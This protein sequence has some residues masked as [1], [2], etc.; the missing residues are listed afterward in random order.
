MILLYH[1]TPLKM[2][3]EIVVM[4]FGFIGGAGLYC[5][6]FFKYTKYSYS[7]FYDFCYWF[8]GVVFCISSTLL[9][10]F[11]LSLFTTIQ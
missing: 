6:L 1:I 3:L 8:G 10:M 4:A 2:L 11:I 5:Y 9:C 7:G